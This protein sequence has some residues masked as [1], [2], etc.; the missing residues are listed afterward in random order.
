MSNDKIQ[1]IPINRIRI[2]NPRKRNAQ[3]FRDMVDSISLVGLKRPITVTATNSTNDSYL[4]D[5]VCGQGRLEAFELL[6]QTKIPAIIIDASTEDCFL[7]SLIENLARRHH[8][9]L[10]LMRDIGT[11]SDRGYS[12]KEIATKTGLTREYVKNILHLIRHG[13][14]RLLAAVERNHIP[15]NVAVEI[16]MS[17][18]DQI[19]QALTDAYERNE[20]RGKKL[21]KARRIIEQRRRRGKAMA[22]PRNTA[23]GRKIT[24]HAMV[25]AYKQ[26]TER[27][28]AMI[29]KSDATERRLLFIISAL[30][31]L[32]NDENFITLLRAEGLET[33]PR[34]IVD[35]IHN[36]KQ[37]A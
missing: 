12:L 25:R 27:Q 34:Q 11:L 7:M 24:A 19:Q 1:Q 14:E 3:K 5:L 9:S 2:L 8:S 29:L 15:V 32:F 13:E 31:E 16:A 10:E 21:Q 23:S 28:R 18:D 30:K 33:V 36:R 26:E 6:E 17:N 20:L 37:P 4:Y 35:L 22:K